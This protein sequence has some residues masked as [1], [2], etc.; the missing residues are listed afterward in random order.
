MLE[1]YGDCVGPRRL[2]Q[3]RSCAIFEKRESSRGYYPNFR[4]A[5]TTFTY[6]VRDVV[7]WVRDHQMGRNLVGGL[8]STGSGSSVTDLEASNTWETAAIYPGTWP[9]QRLY[10]SQGVHP[11]QACR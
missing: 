4:K 3:G 9:I 8:G 6:P 5:A 7:I 11:H 10:Q 1:S 2:E